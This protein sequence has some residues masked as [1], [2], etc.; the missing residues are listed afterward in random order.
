MKRNNDVVWLTKKEIKSRVV[1]FN[2]LSPFSGDHN[3]VVHVSRFLSSPDRKAPMS[4]RGLE[5]LKKIA[6]VF[7]VPDSYPL[8]QWTGWEESP[9]RS[10][11]FPGDYECQT[12]RTSLLF[13]DQRTLE[14]QIH[15]QEFMGRLDQF[16]RHDN[17]E[18]Q[19]EVWMA[20]HV[21]RSSIWWSWC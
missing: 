3:E 8:A 11:Q 14:W 21:K 9:R 1:Y 4:K 2:R 15:L 13:G 5:L 10:W 19:N 18:R 6:G 17:E 20:K 16:Q 7:S 12:A